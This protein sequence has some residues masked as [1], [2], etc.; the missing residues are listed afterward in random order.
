VRPP[1]DGSDKFGIWGSGVNAW[2]TTAIDDELKAQLTAS[3]LDIH[4]DAHGPRPADAVR[5]IDL[6][7]LV[8]RAE[9]TTASST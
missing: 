9:R 6:A 5:E 1:D 3:D 8:Q 2:R 4:Y 7:Q